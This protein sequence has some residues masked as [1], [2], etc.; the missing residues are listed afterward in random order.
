MAEVD[1]LVPVAWQSSHYAAIPSCF[2]FVPLLPVNDF[3]SCQ[4]SPDAST[5]PQDGTRD[6]Q[7]P[8]SPAM[9][10][11]GSSS[12]M[13]GHSESIFSTSGAEHAG[14]P[15][16]KDEQ[17]DPPI[18][19]DERSLSPA[20]TEAQLAS[21]ASAD[22]KSSSAAS[23]GEPPTSLT[24]S[25]DVHD[26]FIASELQ[27]G[28]PVDH[29]VDRL[30]RRRSSSNKRQEQKNKSRPSRPEQSSD[31]QHAKQSVPR[32]QTRREKMSD[33]QRR[34]KNRANVRK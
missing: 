29:Y 13:H 5:A 23:T 9:S 25:E 10:G 20:L 15:A 22:E 7:P 32:R 1:T 16:A 31:E 14:S 4:H 12:A 18:P 6:L 27:S 21:R 28:M 3:A 11:F 2:R 17:A 30:E 34:E 19:T 8:S 24:S 33:Q 26:A